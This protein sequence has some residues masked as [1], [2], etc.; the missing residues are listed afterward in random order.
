MIKKDKRKEIFDLDVSQFFN[1]KDIRN[2]LLKTWSNEIE[3]THFR[4]FVE[5]LSDGKQI[6]LERPANLNKGCDFVIKIQDFIIFK[7][8]NDKPPKHKDLLDFIKSNKSNFA[9]LKKE[10]NDVYNC[11]PIQTKYINYEHEIILKLSKWFFI[12]QDITYWAGTGREM[13]WKAIKSEL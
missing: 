3:S 8:G 4:Y 10:L 13:L 6:Y 2:H 1:K 11:K 12:E 9:N 7:N 5:T